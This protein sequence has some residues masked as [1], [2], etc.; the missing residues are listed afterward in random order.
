MA[1][2][3]SCLTFLVCCIVDLK[4]FAPPITARGFSS[5]DQHQTPVGEGRG[6]FHLGQVQVS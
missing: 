1:V 5:D 2:A 4:F 6:V 3:R